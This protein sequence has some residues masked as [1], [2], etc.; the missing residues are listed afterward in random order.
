[1][2]I[3]IIVQYLLAYTSSLNTCV[4]NNTR[5][6]VLNFFSFFFAITSVRKLLISKTNKQKKQKP[7]P[8]QSKTKRNKQNHGKWSTG[9]G[10]CS[11]VCVLPP[12][13]PN[14]Q[15]LFSLVKPS[16][17]PRVRHHGFP[18]LL[19]LNLDDEYRRE[20]R[21]RWLHYTE[22][23]CHLVYWQGQLVV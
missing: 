17:V 14:Y 10:R 13:E 4:S 18:L 19:N 16:T 20:R 12:V 21:E 8:K 11:N 1:M 23:W 15:S 2:I 7:P 22:D 3:I 9:I 6:E 5:D